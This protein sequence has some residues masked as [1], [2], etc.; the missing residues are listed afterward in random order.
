MDIELRTCTTCCTTFLVFRVVMETLNLETCFLSLTR[1]CAMKQTCGIPIHS[2]KLSNLCPLGALLHIQH[3]KRKNFRKK[4]FMLFL[5]LEYVLHFMSCFRH[6]HN[7]A[8]KSKPHPFLISEYNIISQHIWTAKW[9]MNMKSEAFL[10]KAYY[11]RLS[12]PYS[13][14]LVYTA[15][16]LMLPKVV[17]C[18]YAG[19][20]HWQR[21]K[22]TTMVLLHLGLWHTHPKRSREHIRSIHLLFVFWNK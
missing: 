2:R 16:L 12:F 21:S 19:S 13:K 20:L 7:C 5:C 6:T 14:L 9:A 1:T 8:N 18:S 4:P 22:T 10:S 11:S 15:L 17:Y 3:Y